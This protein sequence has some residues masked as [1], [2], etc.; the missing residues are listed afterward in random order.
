[1]NIT[2][3]C[4]VRLNRKPD[5]NELLGRTIVDSARISTGTMTIGEA[6]SKRDLKLIRFLWENQHTSPFRHA[7]LSFHIQAPIHVLRQWWKHQIGAAWSEVSILGDWNEA[8]GRYKEFDAKFYSAGTDWRRQTGKQMANEQMSEIDAFDEEQ[9]HRAFLKHCWEQ[10]QAALQRGLCKEQARFY[11]PN[12][13]FSECYWT[14]S[15]QGILWF[16]H[17]RLKQDA[18]KEI[19]DCA[20]LILDEMRPYLEAADLLWTFD[21]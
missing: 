19:R 1:M 8:S 3:M 7:Y 12:T 17:Q 15:L 6:L 4:T 21:E 14:V 11:L 2:N 9:K 13:L 5:S 10:Y 20:H 16:L 18:Q